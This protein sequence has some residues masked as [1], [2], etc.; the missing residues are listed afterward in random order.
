MLISNL[1]VEFAVV[2]VLQETNRFDNFTTEA[3]IG[4]GDT[5]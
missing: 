1:K 3:T 2:E 5:V 4:G